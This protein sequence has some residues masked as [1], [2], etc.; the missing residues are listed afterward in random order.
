MIKGDKK[1]SYGEKN[2]EKNEKRSGERNIKELR[3]KR[4]NE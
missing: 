3:R 4:M 2:K 1:G